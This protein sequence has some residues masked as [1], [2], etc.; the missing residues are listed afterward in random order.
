MVITNKQNKQCSAKIP[1]NSTG[2]ALQLK[3]NTELVSPLK[4]II[5][6]NVKIVV[7]NVLLYGC[8][9]RLIYFYALAEEDSDSSKNISYY[10]LNKQF[11]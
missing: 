7:V 3:G 11:E 5:P 10:K 9:L 8:S 2:T 1:K 6:E 4:E